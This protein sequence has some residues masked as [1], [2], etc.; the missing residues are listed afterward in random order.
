[1]TEGARIFEFTARN[2]EYTRSLYSI[3]D[4]S[5]VCKF[6]YTGSSCHLISNMSFTPILY[7]ILDGQQTRNFEYTESEVR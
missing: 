1:M 3:L 4:V 7:S 2:I 5:T 6:E